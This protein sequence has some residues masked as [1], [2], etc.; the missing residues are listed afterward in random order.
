MI[1][2]L[3]ISMLPVILGGVFNML[4]VKIKALDFLRIPIDGGK[5]LKGKRIFGNSKTVLGFIGMMLGSALATIF[6]GMFLKQMGLEHYNVPIQ[7]IL[8]FYPEHY[9]DLHI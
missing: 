9:L 4:F 8:I 7:F 5:S 2:S 1:I 3:Y 6:W